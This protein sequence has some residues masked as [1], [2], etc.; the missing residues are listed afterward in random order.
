MNELQNQVV[1][2]LQQQ[3]LDKPLLPSISSQ[4]SSSLLS[5]GDGLKAEYYDNIDFTN[6]K[7]TRTDATVNF[8]WGLG[9]PDS[10]I[11]PDTFS[12]RWTGQVQAKYSE[13]YN[14]YTTSDDGVRLW[15]NGQQIINQFVNQSATEFSGSIALVAGQKYDIKLEYFENTVN[16][17]SKLSWSSASQTKE[18]IPQSQLY[19]QSDVPAIGNGNGLKAEYYDNIDFTNLK[20]TRTDATVNFDWGLGSPDSS[21]APDTFSARWTGQVQAKYSETYNFY[22]TS[23]DGVRLW[24]NGKQIINQFVNQS[25]TEF[26]GSIA[27]V[28]GQKYDIKLEYFENTVNAVSKLSWSSASQTKEIIPQSQLYSQSDVPAIGNGNGLTAEYYDNI[29]FTN[30]KQTRIDATVNFDWGLGSPDPSIAPDTFS[31]RWTGQVQAKYSETYNFYTSSDDGVRL[32]VN[33]QQII[34]KFVDQSPTENTGSIALVA[35]QKY[36]IRLEYYENTVTAVSKL[37]WSS[38]SQTKEIIPQSQLYSQSANGNGNGLKA[39]YYDNIDFTNLK[40]TRTDATVNFDWGLGSPDSSIA[41]DTFSARWTGQ[42]QAKY[43]ETYN[44]YTTSDDGVRLWVNGQQIINQFVNQSATEFSGSI[45]LV[46]GQ[47]YDIKLEYFE[48]TVN[49]VSKLSWSSASQTKEIIPQSQLYSTPLQTTIT[50]GSPSTTVNEGAGNVTITL[51]RT[52]DLSSTSS[53]KYATLA[54]T[55]T[56]GVDYGSDGSES[57]G[58]IIFAPGESSR[59]VSIPINDDSSPEVDET[60]SFVIDQPGGATLGLQRTLGVTIQDNDRSGIDF[61]APVVNEGAG[62]VTVVATRGNTVGAASVNYTTVDGTAKAGS[63]YQSKSGTLSFIAGQSQQNIIIPIINDNI[64]ESNETFTLN[65]SNAIGV[66]LTNQQTTITILDDDSGKVLLE[67]VASGLNQPTAFD[68]TADQKRMFVAQ[69]NGVVRVLDNGKLLATPFIDISGQVNDTRDRGLLGIAVHPDFGK[70]PTGN[71]YVYLLYTY[72]PPETTSKDP[73]KNNPNSTLDD[74]DQ[75]GN[76][77]AQLIRVTADPNTNYTTAIAGSQFVLLG[78]NATWNN[79][80]HPDGNSTNVSLGYAPSGI[81]NKDTGKLFTSLQDYL[82]NLDKVQNVQNFIANDS[83][84]HSVGAVR[85]GTDGT[86]FVSLGDGTSYNGIDPRAI[87][88]QDVNNLS[89]KILHIDAITGKGLSSNP[90]YNLTND[91]NSNS[92]KVYNLGLRNPF[93]FTIDQKTNTPVIG[94]VGFD[95]YEEVNV[96][97]PGANFGWPFYEGG[98]DANGNIVSL[99]QPKYATLNAAKDFYSSGKTVTAPVY[100]YKHFSSNSIVLGDFYTGNTFPSIYQGALFVGDFS[101]GTIDAL[102]FDSQGKLASVKRFASQADTPNLGVTTQ[103]TTGLDGNLYYAN[104]TGGEI[105][106]F[107]PA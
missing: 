105:D 70:S 56:A 94:D 40:Q 100:T 53:I 31:A 57:A 10:S 107:R 69:K 23:D 7:Q 74:P 52:G 12:A 5:Q 81:L 71:N 8:D 2:P 99:Q 84:S 51:L 41:P 102:T 50:L 46:A 104:L 28:A 30:L 22:T 60:F 26:S 88:V 24:V 93:R 44:F 11:A 87:R 66:Q 95:T 3:T 62:T 80:S 85:F 77:T 78:T 101:Q 61:S 55:A 59:Q 29:D 58:T 98:L 33:G 34:N 35:G 15:V 39:E 14:F 47:K 65:F 63:D 1:V 90:F 9:S 20:Q 72:D 82:N 21:I 97:K 42:V 32:W 89:G 18:I 76:R 17:V 49:A 75:N 67:T 45:A 64:G 48:N 38:A 6:L 103:I 16:A 106:R 54:G 91:P 25:A 83:E 79:I 37:A 96:G 92:S 43:S 86:L 19:R 4:A 73:T 68:W 36:D 13:T 27:L